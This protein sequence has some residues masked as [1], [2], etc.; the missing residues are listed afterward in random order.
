MDFADIVLYIHILGW[1][2]WLGTDVGVFIG[3]KFTEN[4]SYSVETRLTILKL[5][6][7][8]DM[9]PRIA[10]PVVFT[11]GVYLMNVRYGIAFP[12][13]PIGMVLGAIWTG[14]VVT[15]LLNEDG[16]SLGDLAKKGVLLI[17]ACVVLLMGGAAVASLFGAAIFPLWIALKWLAYAWIAIFAIGIDI[18]FK[19]AI[20]D[21][22][23]LQ[24][25]GASDELNASLTKNLKPVYLTVL[26]VYFGTMVAA[27]FGVA[28]PL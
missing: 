25:E 19:P 11:T 28:K 12:S 22:V 23:R 24:T 10:V 14:V 15:G 18:T 6:M 5:A 20:A 8:L 16:T 3:A 4:P 9:A 1:V 17:Q 27:Y 26:A 13:L 21:Y 2:I 7:I